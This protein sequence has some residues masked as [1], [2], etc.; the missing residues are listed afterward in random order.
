MKIS[1]NYTTC[2]ATV[3][4]STQYSSKCSSKQFRI[5]TSNTISHLILELLQSTWRFKMLFNVSDLSNL[6][7]IFC[8]Y[9]E[10][11]TCNNS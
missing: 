7:N 10:I 11:G 2:N 5:G 6:E 9:D 4:Q 1:I 8:T 3:Q